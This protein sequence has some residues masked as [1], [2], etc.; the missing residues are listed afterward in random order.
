MQITKRNYILV[1]FE[2][3]QV[4]VPEQISGLPVKLVIFV[5][6]AQSHLPVELVQRLLKCQCTV[7]IY[8][9]AGNGKNALDFQMAFYAGRV[10]EK[11]PEACIHIASHDKGF[12][13]L[14]AHIKKQGRCCSRVDDFKSLPFLA[15]A[16]SKRQS[17]KEDFTK[18]SQSH[19]IEIAIQRLTKMSSASR[20]RKLRTLK[21]AL[22]AQYAKQLSEK[23]VEEV[24]SE[25]IQSGHVLLGEKESVSY[26]L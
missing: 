11:E 6:K 19:R 13:P 20:P 18:S 3:T 5:G 16:E 2:N 26:K 22:H 17:V 23:E 12:D 21:S 7:E 14:V 15:L 8:E 4:V 9:S 1:D 24:L 25:L 10:F